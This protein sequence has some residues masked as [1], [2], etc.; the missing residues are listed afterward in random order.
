MPPKIPKTKKE[1]SNE[2]LEEI[3]E[4]TK[5]KIK[6][7]TKKKAEVV[8][9][10]VE[11]VEVVEQLEQ[12]VEEIEE[13]PKKVTKTKKVSKKEKQVELVEEPVE[14][15]NLEEQIDLDIKI[16]EDKINLENEPGFSFNWDDG[17]Q[18][19]SVLKQDK[20]KEKKTNP[21]ELVKEEIKEE[22]KEEEVAKSNTPTH[23]SYKDLR[24]Q[25]SRFNSVP[26]LNNSNSKNPESNEEIV[27]INKIFGSGLKSNYKNSNSNSNS[28]FINENEYKQMD[29]TVFKGITNIQLASA[30]FVRLKNDG[31]PL[32]REA[33]GI[34]R[35]LINPTGSNYKIN[36]PNRFNNHYG[37]EDN[38][39]KPKLDDD[40]VKKD[41]SK[42]NSKY[43]KRTGLS[44]YKSQRDESPEKINGE[45][46]VLQQIVPR[47]SKKK[48]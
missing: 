4:D 43:N 21:I 7:T 44:N 23:I 25:N 46:E 42:Y 8:E 11:Q 26:N 16:E 35:V 24:K 3:E 37:S 27:G 38:Q 28:D 1:V 17:S 32:S 30:L 6:R 40:Y 39:F 18:T 48:V 29:L 2:V 12:V 15:I 14:D 10:Q 5:P 47:G 19:K 9:Q 36:T 33:L 20:P 45:E 41:K 13:K 22:V 31:N 34:Y